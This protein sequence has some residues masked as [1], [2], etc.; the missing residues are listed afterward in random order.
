MHQSNLFLYLRFPLTTDWV[1]NLWNYICC[2]Q[3]LFDKPHDPNVKVH[4]GGTE[5]NEDQEPFLITA[6]QIGWQ[7]FSW[8]F[9]IAYSYRF[10]FKLVKPHEGYSCVGVDVC[11][12]F[13]RNAKRHFKKI[14]V[15]KS[16][17][18]RWLP[19]DE[20]SSE[21]PT[22]SCWSTWPMFLICGP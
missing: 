17:P 15:T 4:K 7:T 5:R 16:E 9:N 3:H 8:M 19:W 11:W 10:M 12:I 1:W 2:I 21:E 13:G 22:W 18:E 14:E 6:I 20:G